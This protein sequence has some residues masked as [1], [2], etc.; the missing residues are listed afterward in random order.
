ME[1]I[2]LEDVGLRPCY[3]RLGP[4]LLALTAYTVE[5]AKIEPKVGTTFIWYRCLPECIGIG[6]VTRT[7][8][9][10]VFQVDARATRLQ[11]MTWLVDQWTPEEQV[12]LRR[13]FGQPEW[14]PMSDWMLTDDPLVL[15]V[16]REVRLPGDPPLQGEEELT[17]RRDLGLLH[18]EYA[19]WLAEI[20]DG[21][22]AEY[23]TGLGYGEVAA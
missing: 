6:H 16:P 7:G 19:A 23:L 4:L 14:G 3:A 2:T 20:R 18:H 5:E 10:T 15:Y 12:V 9:C 22:C 17:R 8:G 11:V 21:R 1:I 13:A